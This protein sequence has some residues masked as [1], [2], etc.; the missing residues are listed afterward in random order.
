MTMAPDSLAVAVTVTDV[1]DSMTA[2]A[3]RHDRLHI[4]WPERHSHRLRPTPGAGW[5]SLF[6]DGGFTLKDRLVRHQGHR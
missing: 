3:F 2:P 5:W 4:R 1:G 6:L